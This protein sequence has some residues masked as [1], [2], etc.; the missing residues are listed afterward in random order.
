MAGVTP[1]PHL[2][3]QAEELPVLKLNFPLYNWERLFIECF[4]VQRNKAPASMIWNMVSLAVVSEKR[5]LLASVGTRFIDFMSAKLLIDCW[6][7]F[8]FRI[9]GVFVSFPHI[10]CVIFKV[11][12]NSH[13]ESHSRS[14]YFY[15]SIQTLAK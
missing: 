11:C 12:S 8:N 14:E 10:L 4:A 1:A 15:S 5:V 3:C 2:K 7:F 9:F 6:D 13:K